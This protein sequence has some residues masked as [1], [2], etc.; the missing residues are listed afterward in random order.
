MANVNYYKVAKPEMNFWAPEELK[1]F[2]DTV[3]SD[4]Y[5]EIDIEIAYRTKIFTLIGFALGDRVGETRALKFND[6]NTKNNTVKIS[7]SINYDTKSFDFFSNT[8]TPH[9]QREIFVTKKLI[10]EVESYKYFLKYDLGYD[11]KNDS[12]IFLIILQINP[13]A[14]SQ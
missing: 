14:I 1:I 4:I 11:V 7:H 13:I 3:N 6:F 5:N 2:L 12:I 9:S 8:K 10:E